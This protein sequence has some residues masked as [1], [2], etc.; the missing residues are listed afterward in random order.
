MGPRARGPARRGRPRGSRRC[1][2]R[3]CGRARSGRCTSNRA[4]R[5]RMPGPG[6]PVRVR[7]RVD[8]RRATRARSAFS[9]TEPSRSGKRV[10]CSTWMPACGRRGC[11]CSPTTRRVRGRRRARRPLGRARG[12][13][14]RRR[15]PRR[16]RSDDHRDRAAARRTGAQLPALPVDPQCAGGAGGCRRAPLRPDRRLRDERAHRAASRRAAP[17]RRVPLAATGVS[18]RP[19]RRCRPVV[20]SGGDRRDRPRRRAQRGQQD[21]GAVRA[22]TRRT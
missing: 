8:L 14:A 10:T 11:S 22:P 13:H 21:R 9:A 15:A 1:R 16:A 17:G 2:N 20:R 18:G 5:S 3:S 12:L 4:R 19:R 7:R 6:R